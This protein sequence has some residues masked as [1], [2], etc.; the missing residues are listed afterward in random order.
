MRST[1]VLDWPMSLIS[2]LS[3]CV[4]AC[5]SITTLPWILSPVVNSFEFLSR[6]TSILGLRAIAG[7][8]MLRIMKGKYT[9]SKSLELLGGQTHAA[10]TEEILERQCIIRILI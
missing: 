7:D 6:C 9:I 1:K 2:M 5:A 3:K 8:S 4:S 10:Q